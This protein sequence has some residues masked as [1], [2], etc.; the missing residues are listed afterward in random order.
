METPF[1]TLLSQNAAARL[2]NLIKNHKKLRWNGP[3][4]GSRFAK[5]G[6]DCSLPGSSVHGTLQARMLEWVAILFSR[7]SF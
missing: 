4:W 2:A 3:L 7:G 5:I 1:F 6:G